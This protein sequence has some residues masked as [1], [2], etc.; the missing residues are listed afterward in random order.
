[1]IGLHS[2]IKPTFFVRGYL[3]LWCCHTWW[4]IG[5]RG[6]RERALTGWRDAHSGGMPIDHVIL[7]DK[8]TNDVVSLDTLL[9]IWRPLKRDHFFIH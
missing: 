5:E 1:M 4:C 3:L 6:E 2:K 8:F 7:Y 9:P